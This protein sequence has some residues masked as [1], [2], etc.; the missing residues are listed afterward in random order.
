MRG[1]FGP[2]AGLRAQR[3]AAKQ[4]RDSAHT[5]EYVIHPN[6]S[7]KETHYACRVCGMAIPKYVIDK[8]EPRLVVKENGA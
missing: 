1:G 8:F 4:Q 7:W 3:R 5:H 6:P 2:G